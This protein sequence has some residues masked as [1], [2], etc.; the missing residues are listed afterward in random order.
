MPSDKEWLEDWIALAVLLLAAV[1]LV[2]R[3]LDII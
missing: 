1:T 2:L 3:L